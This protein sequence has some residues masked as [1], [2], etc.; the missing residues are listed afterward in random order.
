MNVDVSIADVNQRDYD[1]SEKM[2]WIEKNKVAFDRCIQKCE[3]IPEKWFGKL[4]PYVGWFTEI[5]IVPKENTQSYFQH[6]E[7]VDEIS[8]ITDQLLF[9]NCWMSGENQLQ[10]KYH[11]SHTEFDIRFEIA[12]ES[13]DVDDS[14]NRLKKQKSWLEGYFQR[15]P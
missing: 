6:L 13:A 2:Q 15:Q 7:Q 12:G 14:F 1:G 9:D 11:I 8:K 4:R 10:V 3:S 5:T